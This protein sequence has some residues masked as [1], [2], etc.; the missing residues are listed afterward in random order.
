MLADFEW[1]DLETVVGI[2]YF[3]ALFAYLVILA[4]MV[5]GAIVLLNLLIAMMAKTFDSIDAE[6]K[7]QIT[8][9]RFRLA[10]ELDE[11][12]SFMLGYFF[13]LCHRRLMHQKKQKKMNDVSNMSLICAA[14]RLARLL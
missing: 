4:Y 9:A 13:I 5:I 11:E 8:F 1:G 2:N 3:Y 14:L 12:S 10:I 6:T 7:Q